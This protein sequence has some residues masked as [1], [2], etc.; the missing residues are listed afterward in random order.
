MRSRIIVIGTILVIGAWIGARSNRT[1]V[2]KSKAEVA[3]DLWNDR[4]SKKARARLKK[5]LTHR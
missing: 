3:R 5:K 2:K 4:R 1:V